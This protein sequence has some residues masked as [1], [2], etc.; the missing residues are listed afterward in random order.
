M[1]KLNMNKME[2]EELTNLND[3]G[4]NLQNDNTT[5][6]MLVENEK[7]KITMNSNNIDFND[8]QRNSISL[9]NNNENNINLEKY[10]SNTTINNQHVKYPFS[11]SACTLLQNGITELPTLIKP[12]FPKVG[13]CALAGESDSGKSSFLRDMAI[14]ISSGKPDFLGWSITSTHHS[15]I[16]VT[17]EDDE[18]AISYLLNKQV[19]PSANPELLSKLRFIFD[20][21]NILDKLETELMVA[22]ADLLIIDVFTDL[23]SGELN[24][25]TQVRNYI[26]KYS[27]LAKRYGCLIIY[28]HHTGKRTELL[29]PSKNNL[30]GSQ[31]FEAKMRM[32][33]ELRIDSIDSRFRHFC[34]VKGNYLDFTFKTESYKLEFLPDLTFR[35]TGERVPFTSLASNPE[36]V[37]NNYHFKVKARQ[38]KTQGKSISKILIQLREEGCEV[39][40]ST[41]GNWVK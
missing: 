40:R 9:K 6:K 2:N 29:R 32:V 27:D 1:Q 21:E 36:T 22:P 35:N 11:I 31:G 25:N 30:L 20:S 26:N 14:S 24:A 39:S 19:N 34:I 16:Y 17:T 12:I 18:F 38:L 3:A 13:V 15:V 41:I 23:F 4:K 37:P 33:I 8:Y 28:L 10:T 7:T 5:Y